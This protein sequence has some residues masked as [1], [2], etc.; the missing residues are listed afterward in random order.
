MNFEG[1]DPTLVEVWNA[2]ERRYD[3]HYAYFGTMFHFT[4]RIRNNRVFICGYGKSYGEM[5]FYPITGRFW[6]F[7]G[8]RYDI[9]VA[10][11]FDVDRGIVTKSEDLFPK[12]HSAEELVQKSQNIESFPPDPFADLL[13]C[14]TRNEYS[15]DDFPL[16]ETYVADRED[17][18]LEA[19]VQWRENRNWWQKVLSFFAGVAYRKARFIETVADWLERKAS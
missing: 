4:L 9:R 1:Q 5:Q 19:F 11:C 7:S 6:A 8:S 10:V 15:L 14:K 12:K 2:E 17:P 16:Q 18:L 13:L 3:A